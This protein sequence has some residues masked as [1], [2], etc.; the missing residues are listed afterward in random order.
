MIL[1]FKNKLAEAVWNG[2]VG[3]GFPADL[4]R[5]AQRKLAMVNAAVS[6]EALRVPPAN[7]LEALKGDRAGQHS[8]RVNDQ[9]RICF[10]WRDGHAVDVEIVD[11]H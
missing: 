4:V 10:I 7:R 2:T 11:Y 3:K 9:F 6:L 5:P 8:I 1:S